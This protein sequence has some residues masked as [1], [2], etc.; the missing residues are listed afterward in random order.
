MLGEQSAYAE[1]CFTG[2]FVGTN[3]GIHQ[4]LTGQLPSE[5]RTFN[6][7]FIPIFLET[8]PGK[9]RIGAGLSCGAL[10]TVSKG[11]AKKDIVLCPNGTGQYRVGQITGGYTYAP[12][13]VLPHRR[14]VHWLDHH[15]SKTDLSDGLRRSCGSIG[16]VAALEKHRDEIE[17]LLAG[18]TTPRITTTDDSIEDPASFAVE[19]HLEDFLVANWGA[20]ELSDTYDIYAD[21]HETLG[22]Q[23]QTDT[24]PIDILA[25]S[26]DR[27]TI[28]VI[29]LKKGR[30][31]DA[32]V[33]QALRY[34]GYVKDEL[35]EP[36]QEV[37]GLV[38]ALEDDQRL[39]RAL[40]MVPSIDFKRYAV[41]FQL[42][43]T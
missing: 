40:S 34:M 24:G 1:E 25:I 26:K 28:L 4:D 21:E 9:S 3:F 38:I 5:W 32:V 39:R 10:W 42:L 15:I 19:K 7:H 12:N 2:G 37:R 29:E 43:T 30:A 16:T 14:P 17:R 23:Y 11:I 36:G 35:A 22:Q 31:S 8:H 6:K 27:K 18:H 33:G 20:T 13:Q 41:S